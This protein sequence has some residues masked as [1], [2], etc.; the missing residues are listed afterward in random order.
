MDYKT[1]YLGSVFSGE[2]ANEQ[3][4][5]KA[6]FIEILRNSFGF[7]RTESAAIV[8]NIFDEISRALVERREVKLSNFG[9]FSTRDKVARPGRNPKTGADHEI[10]ARCVVSFIP[11][12]H[13]REAVAGFQ[14]A[15]SG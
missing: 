3:T 6:D 11:A 13:L 9:T 14:G 1:E 8:D 15:A 12:P 7:S 4:L 2:E 10:S 5:T